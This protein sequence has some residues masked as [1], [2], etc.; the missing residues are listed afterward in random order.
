MALYPLCPEK[1]PQSN[2]LYVDNDREG[3]YLSR[4]KDENEQQA[5]LTRGV[6]SG[7]RGLC[8]VD[9]QLALIIAAWLLLVGKG[10]V[11]QHFCN[12]ASITS[13]PWLGIGMENINVMA[14]VSL[15]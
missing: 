15:K 4:I 10:Y 8:T 14:I 9:E 12:G 11:F 7:I 13:L 2:S 6:N 1:N 5:Q 3:D